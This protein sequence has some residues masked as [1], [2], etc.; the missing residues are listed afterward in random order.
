LKLRTLLSIGACSALVLASNTVLAGSAGPT[1]ELSGFVDTSLSTAI[2]PD[3]A[4]KTGVTL[5]L[6]QVELDVKANVLP[7]LEI[8][9]DFNYMPAAGAATMDA[10]VEQGYALWHVDGTEHG[11][12]IRAGKWNAPVGFETIDPTGLYQFSQGLL[13]SMATPANLT[14]FALG[15][16]N[17]N[18]EAQLWLT[19]DWDTPGTAEDG[20]IGGRINVSLG[21]TG[22]VGLSSTYGAINDDPARLLIDLDAALTFDAVTVGAE[23]NYGKQDDLS[24]IG[25]L[26]MAN[27]AVSDATSFTARFDYLDR[28]IM[29]APYKGMS[30]TAAGLFTLASSH[31]GSLAFITEVRA[32]LPDVGDEILTGSLELLATFE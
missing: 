10:L 9:A 31:N 30:A 8:I 12:F 16:S 29:D 17:D 18:V 15:W 6:D 1:I 13:F 32:D 7:G 23:F 24:S 14:G 5:G 21:D 25:F 26:V 11:L 4:R 28:E 19:N 22:S 20:S 3:A 2:I 27:Y